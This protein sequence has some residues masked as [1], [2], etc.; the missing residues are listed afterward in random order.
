MTNNAAYINGWLEVVFR[1]D[2]RILV[3][4]ALRSQQAVEYILHA[5]IVGNKETEPGELEPEAATVL[6]GSL[7][8]VWWFMKAFHFD[9]G[10]F[11]L[12]RGYGA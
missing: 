3:K 9:E 4:A 8:F 11:I 7:F 2:K 1:G 6:T 12:V 10:F 5:R